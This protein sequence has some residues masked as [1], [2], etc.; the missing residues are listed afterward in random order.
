MESQ[1]LNKNLL[2]RLDGFHF[3]VLRQI[4]GFHSSY[5]HKVVNASPA[6]CS[7]EYIHR[8]VHRRGFQV[9]TVTQLVSERRL[10]YFGHIWRHPNSTEHKV[11]F[12]DVMSFR[13]LRGNFRPGAP[14]VHWPELCMVE[15]SN[16]ITHLATG[17]RP[18]TK[19][20]SSPYYHT[21]DKN[22]IFSA[23]GPHLH[24][25]YDTTQHVRSIRPFASDRA[26]WKRVTG[27]KEPPS[28]RE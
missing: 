4:L 24:N 28:R 6:E 23:M 20:L 17:F 7:N 8:E 18:D 5:Y 3:K 14:R 15:S 2:K 22:E 25:F 13:K 16:R 27:K 10:K 21:P 11:A 9:P 1:V 19:Y 26:Q 12:N